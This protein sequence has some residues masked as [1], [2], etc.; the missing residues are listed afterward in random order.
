MPYCVS[1]TLIEGNIYP[2][3]FDLNEFKGSKTE[4]LIKL[5][6][7][8]P[9]KT[10]K[11]LNDMCPKNPDLVKVTLQNNQTLEKEIKNV[12][13]GSI[14]PMHKEE[15]IEKF[16]SCGGTKEQLNYLLN[17]SFEENFSISKFLS[18]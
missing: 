12:L 15:V 13:G 1:K 17:L 3:S 5:T 2:N 9:Y 11:E 8:I 16:L 18:M 4:K 14:L 7:V 10:S 6:K